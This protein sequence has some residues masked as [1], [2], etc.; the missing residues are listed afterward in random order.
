LFQQ[1]VM[2]V[3]TLQ[4][5]E[6]VYFQ[7]SIYEIDSYYGILFNYQDSVCSQG[8][9]SSIYI[10]YGNI[11]LIDAGVY[12]GNYPCNQ[13]YAS[14]V[15][16]EPYAGIYYIAFYGGSNGLQSVIFTATPQA[17][18]EGYAGTL[19][20]LPTGSACCPNKGMSPVCK[21]ELNSMAAGAS[22]PN[23]KLVNNNILFFSVGLVQIDACLYGMRATISSTIANYTVIGRMSAIPE[24]YNPYTLAQTYPYIFT[25]NNSVAVITIP[26]TP[27]RT[28]FFAILIG[29]NFFVQRPSVYN[30]TFTFKTDVLSTLPDY[31]TQN[32]VYGILFGVV[33]PMAIVATL[34]FYFYRNQKQAAHAYSRIN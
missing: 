6:I 31:D 20:W 17:C 11:P 34:V 32:I 24:P 7:F 22:M 26:Y 3:P 25:T 14:N 23:I 21:A 12:D 18:T 5:N 4:P 8:D 28:W 19:C 33:A 9:N 27:N 1:A 10:R 13:L 15:W 16:L 2:Q 29:N 30:G